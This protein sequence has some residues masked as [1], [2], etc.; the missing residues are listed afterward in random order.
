MNKKILITGASGFIGSFLVEEALKQGFEVFAGMR[1]SSSKKHLQDSRIHFLELDLHSENTLTE[2]FNA[3]KQAFGNIDFVI[4]NAGITQAKKK[5]DF[6]TVNCGYTQHLYDS[7]NKSEMALE[8]FVLISSLAAYGPGNTETFAPIEL[9]DKQTPIT[10]YGKSK[11][12][13]EEYIKSAAVFPYIIINPTAV[14]GPRDKD[15]LEFV[16]LINKGI[17]PYIGIN[18]QMISM[19]YVKDLT[20]AVIS[21]L[22]INSSNKSY[23]VSDT[24]AYNKE[25]LGMIA[26]KILN[27]KTFKIKIP[28]LPIRIIIASIEKIQ[29]L[30]F[31]SL[32]FLNTEKVNEI[33]SPNWLCNSTGLWND[34]SSSPEYYLEKGLT[35]TIDWY[36][37]HTWL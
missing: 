24:K 19:I 6:Y 36:K 35:E 10:V 26:K 4:H 34:L 31:G 23:F 12:C 27:K 37:T 17:E 28:S 16:K 22:P 11:V 15:F 9:S 1:K 7:L 3:F 21:L 30:I 32:P 8:K 29:G 18:K 2:Q 13:A 25:E 20:R 5:E 14:Y 33:S